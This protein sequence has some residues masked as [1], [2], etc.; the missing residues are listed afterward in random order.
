M[1]IFIRTDN[2]VCSSLYFTNG[3]SAI[4]S[5]TLFIFLYTSNTCVVSL[6]LCNIFFHSVTFLFTSANILLYNPCMNYFILLQPA[7]SLLLFYC[8]FIFPQMA[9]ASVIIAPIFLARYLVSTDRTKQTDM[10]SLGLLVITSVFEPMQTL[11]FAIIVLVPVLF[12]IHF[13]ARANAPA[14]VPAVFA[15]LPITAI[16]ATLLLVSPEWLAAVQSHMLDSINILLEPFKDVAI[17]A[18]N[19]ESVEYLRD[20]GE[21][22]ARSMALITPAISYILISLSVFVADKSTPLLDANNMPIKREFKLPEMLVWGLIVGGFCILIDTEVTKYISYNT[23]IIFTLLYLY[24]GVQ[25]VTQICDRFNLSRLF[26]TAIAL[27]VLIEPMMLVTVAMMGLFSI[28][29]KPKWLTQ[30][31]A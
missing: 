8:M 12:L 24:Q 21:K 2:F 5:Y 17:D 3:F 9:L 10:I 16:T 4:M 25:L 6:T 1:D 23:L 30:D 20:N 19:Y 11:W 28:W 14:Y 13:R 31:K 29:Y 15:P 22:V 7:T 18:P 26:R 27:F